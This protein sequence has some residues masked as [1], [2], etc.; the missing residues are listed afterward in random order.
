MIARTTAGTIRV[1]RGALAGCLL[2]QTPE[3]SAAIRLDDY[4][5]MIAGLMH[6][7]IDVVAALY[8]RIGRATVSG[9]ALHVELAGCHYHA[10]CSDLAAL[11][12][13]R[14]DS[15]ALGLL[16]PEYLNTVPA[17]ASGRRPLLG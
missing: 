15:V 9:G 1:G 2:L 3:R 10:W 11:L 7:P 17:L 12:E 4:H 8:D 16:V 13:G 14:R 6:R 5:D